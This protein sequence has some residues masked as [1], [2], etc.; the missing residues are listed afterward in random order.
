[1]INLRLLKQHSIVKFLDFK[2]NFLT[3]PYCFVCL[4]QRLSYIVFFIQ[5]KQS[6]LQ[7]DLIP[8]NFI[9]QKLKSFLQVAIK[10]T[11][12]FSHTE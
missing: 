8:V 6:N 10:T 11:M 12:K 3:F 5:K 2:S 1:M 7:W 4:L 9:P